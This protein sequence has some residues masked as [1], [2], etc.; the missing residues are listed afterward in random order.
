MN[1]QYT[2]QEIA[3]VVFEIAKIGIFAMDEYGGNI[4]CLART[5]F[6]KYYG[7]KAPLIYLSDGDKNNKFKVFLPETY[8]SL[9][10]PI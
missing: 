8:S 3:E 9:T 5:A 1:Y 10:F 7:C 2:A 6:E 4:S